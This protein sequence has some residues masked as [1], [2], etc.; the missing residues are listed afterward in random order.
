MAFPSYSSP[1]AQTIMTVQRPSGI[2]S[3]YAF[4]G[5][6]YTAPTVFTSPA[7]LTMG[8]E[9]TPASQEEKWIFDDLAL[10]FGLSVAG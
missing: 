3:V 4:G 1:V 9:Y 10:S 2:A 6:L 7:L 8:A 5:V